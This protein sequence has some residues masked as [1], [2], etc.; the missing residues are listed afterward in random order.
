MLFLSSREEEPDTFS[1]GSFYYFYGR[2]FSNIS[3]M[4]SETI[5][6]L[7]DICASDVDSFMIGELAPKLPASRLT[8]ELTV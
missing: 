1:H 4:E 2:S 3:S 8:F 5:F 6:S 7:L